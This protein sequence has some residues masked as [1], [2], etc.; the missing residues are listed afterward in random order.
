[1]TPPTLL[2]ADV[3]FPLMHYVCNALVDPHKESVLSTK[4]PL[5]YFMNLKLFT[6]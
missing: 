6:T 3:T 4:P 2:S 5:P 1:M